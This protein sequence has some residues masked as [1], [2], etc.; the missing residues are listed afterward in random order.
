MGGVKA[1][2]GGHSRPQR[3]AVLE[4]RLRNT[5]KITRNGGRGLFFCQKIGRNK[6][7]GL[8]STVLGAPRWVRL[9]EVREQ[10]QGSLSGLEGCGIVDPDLILSV[11][12]SSFY[13]NILSTCVD[14]WPRFL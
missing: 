1:W 3:G 2:G 10:P 9:L 14:F 6:G 7:R 11:G 4:L 12:G 13:V 5:W 8:M